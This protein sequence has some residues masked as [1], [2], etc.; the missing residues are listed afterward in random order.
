MGNDCLFVILSE[1]SESKNLRID[2]S[3]KILRL[4]FVSLRMTGG[5]VSLRMTEKWTMNVGA[6]NDRPKKSLTDR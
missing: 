3:A 5:N 1:R 6:V 2:G 4:H